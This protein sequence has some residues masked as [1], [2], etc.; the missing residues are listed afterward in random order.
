MPPDVSGF[1]T[2]EIRN[3]DYWI[4]HID[5]DHTA[6]SISDESHDYAWE[7][8]KMGEELPLHA[9]L[10]SR[11]RDPNDQELERLRRRAQEKGLL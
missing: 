6:Q 3:V 8:A 2:E 9:V 7:I 1:S 5:K 10:A 4:D 11:I